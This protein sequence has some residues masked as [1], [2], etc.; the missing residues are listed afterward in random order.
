MNKRSFG[1]G[2]KPPRRNQGCERKHEEIRH[3]EGLLEERLRAVFEEI[4]R[5]ALNEMA[6]QIAQG[7]GNP[8]NSWGALTSENGQSFKLTLECQPPTI[9][10]IP[11]LN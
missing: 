2:M 10:T 9:P 4:L 7:V 1:R 3:T 8:I 5:N 11:S 6:E